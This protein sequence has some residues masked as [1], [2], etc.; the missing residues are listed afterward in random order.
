[1]NLSFHIATDAELGAVNARYAAIGFLPSK[2]G[3][4]IVVASLD[5]QLAGQGRVEPIDARSG[6]LGGIYVLPALAGRGVAR[7]IVDFLIRQTQ[8]P[9]LYC[10]PFSDLAGFYGSMGFA[11]VGDHA[12][13][14]H[15]IQQK[16]EWCKTSY[17]QP[18]LL[19][20]RAAA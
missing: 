8:L 13:V 16:F 10:L 1:M 18:V 4:L 6:E 5:G 9:H 17:D 7:Q 15:Q 20:E 3:E 2:Q 19:L 11:P 12:T 14:A